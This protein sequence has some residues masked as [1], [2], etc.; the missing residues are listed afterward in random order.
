MVILAKLSSRTRCVVILLLLVV[1]TCE[2]ISGLLHSI[3][4]VP[5]PQITLNETVDEWFARSTLPQTGNTTGSWWI[6]Q[7][8]VFKLCRPLWNLVGKEERLADWDFMQSWLREMPHYQ[9]F[10]YIPLPWH[11]IVE[12]YAMLQSKYQPLRQAAHIF[13]RLNFQEYDHFITLGQASLYQILKYAERADFIFNNLSRL[14]VIFSSRLDNLERIVRGKKPLRKEIS[15]PLLHRRN[16][17]IKLNSRTFA[18]KKLNAFFAGSCTCP[19]RQKLAA[20]SASAKYDMSYVNRCGVQTLSRSKFVDFLLNSTWILTPRGSFPA[21]YLMSET[22]Q[23]GSLPVYIF[24]FKYNVYDPQIPVDLLVRYLPYYDA[25]ID[26]R[27]FGLVLTSKDI[28]SIPNILAREDPV[29]RLEFVRRV[30]PFFTV[31][32]T[33]NYMCAILS[34]WPR[35][36]SPNPQKLP[37][38]SRRTADGRLVRGYSS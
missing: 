38:R 11:H 19:I 12:K 9:D 34:R 37:I 29:P 2:E 25:G 22:I 14:K 7:R 18:K 24:G 23:S 31:P 16:L 30:R 36:S 1:I 27:K 33:Y 8:N 32:G 26:W 17:E 20:L 21:T 13:D 28:Y 3:P 5:L 10:V 6:Y 4:V 15:I 35:K